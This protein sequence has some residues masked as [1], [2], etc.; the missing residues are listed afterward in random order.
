MQNIILVEFLKYME[1]PKIQIQKNILWFLN[2]QKVEIL[3]II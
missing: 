2:M 3:M 1:Y